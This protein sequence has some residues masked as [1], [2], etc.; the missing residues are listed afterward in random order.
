MLQ[1]GE[2]IEYGCPFELLQDPQS[3]LMWFVN[4]TGTASGER[5]MEVAR[6]AFEQ[7]N[8]NTIISHY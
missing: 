5:L 6:E 7:Q 2:I 8:Q 4:Q 1:D 3:T